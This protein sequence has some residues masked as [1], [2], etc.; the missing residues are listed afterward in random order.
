MSSPRVV[1]VL[2]AAGTAFL[3]TP[4]L[5]F[6][7]GSASAAAGAPAGGV[8]GGV[9]AAPLLGAVVRTAAEL[10]TGV[11]AGGYPDTFPYGQC[12]YWAALN[13]RVSWS[14]N[15]GEW[16]AN[17]A[18]QGVATTD[19][20]SVGAIAVWPPGTGYDA[21]YGH[22]AVVTAVKPTA[23]TVSEMNYL[24]EGIVDARTVPWPDDRVLGFIP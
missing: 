17:A 16:L 14:G 21:R 22:G 24:G 23:Y 15:A 18:A 20:P 13:H 9:V 2:G 4:L 19:V 6:G 12:T 3:L 11:P 10:L 8:T 7:S 1:L 5:F